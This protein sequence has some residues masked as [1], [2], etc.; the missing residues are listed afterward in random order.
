MGALRRSLPCESIARGHEAYLAGTGPEGHGPTM[1]R[2]PLDPDADPSRLPPE[3]RPAPAT[4]PA[5][6]S[7]ELPRDLA[8]TCADG[9]AALR[10]PHPRDGDVPIDPWVDLCA[11]LRRIQALAAAARLELRRFPGGRRAERVEQLVGDMDTAAQVAAD[12]A[13]EVAR[14]R[15]AA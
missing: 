13:A 15:A 1:P 4:L 12:L 10:R 2:Q 9:P 14:R 3:R 11:E 5:I 7:V 8:V 6:E